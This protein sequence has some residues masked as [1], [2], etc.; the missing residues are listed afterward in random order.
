M[1][2]RWAIFISLG[3]LNVVKDIQEATTRIPWADL[4][5]DLL[6]DVHILKTRNR[7]ELDMILNVKTTIVSQE[8]SDLVSDLI[9]SLLGPL[10]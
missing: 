2:P 10:D 4:G 6:F 5:I 7:A 8:R 3:R 1:G 9:V